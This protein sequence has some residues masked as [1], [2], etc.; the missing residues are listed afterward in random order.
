MLVG[1]RLLVK[2]ISSYLSS[3][4]RTYISIISIKI[5][6]KKEY[7]QSQFYIEKGLQLPHTKE[8]KYAL[9]FFYNM[10]VLH[11]FLFEEPSLDEMKNAAAHVVKIDL[12]S[13]YRAKAIVSHMEQKFDEA[14]EY[15]RKADKLLQ[16]HARSGLGFWVAEQHLFGLLQGKMSNK[17]VLFHTNHIL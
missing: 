5:L 11:Q 15:M 8:M 12:Y 1:Q 6:L 3:P 9:S 14:D 13:Y 17:D 2:A 10:E 7:K 4:S 16:R